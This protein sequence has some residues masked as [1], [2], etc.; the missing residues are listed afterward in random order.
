MK[1]RWAPAARQVPD[2]FTRAMV[3]R[4]SDGIGLPAWVLGLTWWAVTTAASPC[5]RVRASVSAND[6]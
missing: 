6:S 3:K 1:L 4:L 2:S 5:T